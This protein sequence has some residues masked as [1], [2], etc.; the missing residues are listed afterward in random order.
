MDGARRASDAPTQQ[1]DTAPDRWHSPSG[2]GISQA[3]A[4]RLVR[5]RRWRRQTNNQ[6]RVR[7]LV[8]SGTPMDIVRDPR[9][10]ASAEFGALLFAIRADFSTSI[11]SLAEQRPDRAEGDAYR[12]ATHRARSCG[13]R[14]RSAARRTCTQVLLNVMRHRIMRNRNLIIVLLKQ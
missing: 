10:R 9:A 6:G 13:T 3:S 7:V 11:C 1:A 12:T 5:R 14:P 4:S 8:A 2:P